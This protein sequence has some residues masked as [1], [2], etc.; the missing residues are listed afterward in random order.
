VVDESR[1]IRISWINAAV[2]KSQAHIRAAQESGLPRAIG[3]DDPQ[4]PL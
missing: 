3:P 1:E 2:D 4:A